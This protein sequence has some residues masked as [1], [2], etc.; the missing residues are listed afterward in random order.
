MKATVLMIAGV[1]LAFPAGAADMSPRP[2][3][4]PRAP[5]TFTRTAT[6]IASCAGVD[7]RMPSLRSRQRYAEL[8]QHWNR[9]PARPC[10]VRNG[11]EIRS[12]TLG[13][14]FA[15]EHAEGSLGAL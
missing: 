12:V 8:L 6:R 14:C 4:G 2:R 13:S 1:L 11:I 10:Q 3:S 7:R 15:A 5:T 9:V